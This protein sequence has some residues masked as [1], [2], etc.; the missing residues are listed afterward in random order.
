MILFNIFNI[1][2]IKIYPAPS[3]FKVPRYT[4]IIMVNDRH[5]V[6]NMEGII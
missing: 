3:Q 2:S 4:G 6:Y 5:S 1:D